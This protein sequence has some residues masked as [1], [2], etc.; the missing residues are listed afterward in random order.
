MTQR[1]VAGESPNWQGNLEGERP[2]VTEVSSFLRNPHPPAALYRAL[3]LR[4]RRLQ[5]VVINKK[6]YSWT[7]N[8][9]RLAW[10]LDSDAVTN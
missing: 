2:V 9:P 8:N 3:L 10:M 5:V 1:Q 7:W 4:Q 6:D